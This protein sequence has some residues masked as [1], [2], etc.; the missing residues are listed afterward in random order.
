MSHGEKTL[1]VLTYSLLTYSVQAKTLKSQKDFDKFTSMQKEIDATLKEILSSNKILGD[2]AW[3]KLKKKSSGSGIKASEALAG[4]TTV[5]G[6][7]ATAAA[8]TQ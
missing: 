3:A 1:G 8:A 5:L 4:F 7:A 2:S 6:V